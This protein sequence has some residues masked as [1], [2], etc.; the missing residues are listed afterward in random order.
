MSP[1]IAFDGLIRMGFTDARPTRDWLALWTIGRFTRTDYNPNEGDAYALAVRGAGGRVYAS[2]AEIYQHSTVNRT[3]PAPTALSSLECP[4]CYAAIA[5]AALAGP[6]RDRVTQAN[7][8][9]EFIAVQLAPHDVT[10]NR[11]PTWAIVP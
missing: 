7:Q 9:R 1:L 6:V 10:L 8:A 4:F 3:T 2:W 5:R 11:D